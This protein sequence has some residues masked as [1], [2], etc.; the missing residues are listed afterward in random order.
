MG[1]IDK[2]GREDKTLIQR[3]IN[4]MLRHKVE[5]ELVKSRGA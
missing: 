1:R 4:V 3:H 2:L 5:Y